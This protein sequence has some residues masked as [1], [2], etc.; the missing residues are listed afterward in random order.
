M[1][2]GHRKETSASRPVITTDD[3]E[4]QAI[5]A[6]IPAF[7]DGA[8]ITRD[9]IEIV[10]GNKML[11]VAEQ[12]KFM[13]EFVVI[14]IQADD[15][16]NAPEFLYSGHQG[17]NQWIHRGTNQRIRRKYLYSLIAGK[18]TQ[19]AC[20]FGKDNNGNEFNRLNPKSSTTYRLNVIQD[21]QEGM[22]RFAEWMRE[23]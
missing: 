20:S 3:V 12:E 2:R 17:V 1:P 18:K 4:T 11:S 6:T 22:R 9:D 13:N 5:G 19:Y 16:P 15:D 8:P 23:P 14:N 10:P 21:T 7:G